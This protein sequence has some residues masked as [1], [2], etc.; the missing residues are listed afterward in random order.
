M[1]KPFGK[2]DIDQFRELIINNDGWKEV[3]NKNGLQ[4]FTQTV[5]KGMKFKFTTTLFKDVE[6]LQFFDMQRDTEFMKTNVDNFVLNE[7]I[8]E[9]DPCQSVLH[10]VT[11][12]PMFDPRDMVIQ[13]INFRNGDDSEVIILFRSVETD[14]QPVKGSVRAT[15]YNQGFRLVKTA[16]GTLFTMYGHSDMGGK[17]SGMGGETQLKMMSKGMPKKMKEN[18]E[19][20]RKYNEKHKERAKP[21]MEKKLEW[22]NE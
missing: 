12:I 21:W 10:R 22:M 16:E 14:I 2:E 6:P 15:V 20:F 9:L 18:I 5:E 11:K 19:K 3:M 7:V 4:L 8:S 17:M 13:L 1:Y